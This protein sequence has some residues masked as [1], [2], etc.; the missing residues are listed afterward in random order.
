MEALNANDTWD[1]VLCPSNVSIIGSGFF[2]A[3]LISNSEIDRFKA[4][5]IAQG[6]KQE[7]GINYEKIFALVV[8]MSSVR[9]TFSFKY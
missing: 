7:H 2:F 5:Y 9:L 6:H 1:F 3:I 4:R 8:K